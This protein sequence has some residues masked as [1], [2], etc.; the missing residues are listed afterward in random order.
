MG[1]GRKYNVTKQKNDLYFSGTSK[2][3]T[4]DQG[5]SFRR[6]WDAPR[7]RL[8]LILPKTKIIPCFFASVC[9]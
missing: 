4:S 6:L 9:L 2:R 3:L 1:M 7:C 5:D 8:H